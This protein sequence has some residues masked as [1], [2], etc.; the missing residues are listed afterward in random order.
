MYSK[1]KKIDGEEDYND[2]SFIIYIK[3][4]NKLKNKFHQKVH[5]LVPFR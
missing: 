1:T 2:L 4:Y 5:R 3:I